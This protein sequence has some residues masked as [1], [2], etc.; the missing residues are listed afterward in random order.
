L[1]IARKGGRVTFKVAH[2]IFR[3]KGTT[4]KRKQNSMGERQTSA[5]RIK[6]KQSFQ[7]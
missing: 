2:K 1:T 7:L 3:E 6:A 4:K 5:S